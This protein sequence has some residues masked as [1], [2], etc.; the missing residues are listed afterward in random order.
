MC[1]VHHGERLSARVEPEPCAVRA[2]LEIQILGVRG[3]IARIA[4]G[5]TLNDESVDYLKALD[6]STPIAFY[7]HHGVRSLDAAAYL[8]GHGMTNVK[9]LA[10]G[11]DAWSCEVDASVPRYRLEME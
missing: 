2:F 10:G 1:D 3:D 5:R 11:I 7:C 9:S 6:K 4:A 8:I